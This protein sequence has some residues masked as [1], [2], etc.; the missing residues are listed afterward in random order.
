[1]TKK[2]KYHI[3]I[4]DYNSNKDITHIFKVWIKYLHILISTELL[5]I[6][7]LFCK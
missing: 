5:I 1:M 2:I 6:A 4:N 7:L 3:P